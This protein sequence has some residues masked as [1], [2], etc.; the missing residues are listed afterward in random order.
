MYF[1][2]II[3]ILF[4]VLQPFADAKVMFQQHAYANCKKLY[5]FQTTITDAK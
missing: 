5:N 4:Y 2:M 1:T 3:K